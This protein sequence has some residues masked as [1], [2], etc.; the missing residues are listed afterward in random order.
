M[1]VFNVKEFDQIQILLTVIASKYVNLV[2]T[3]AMQGTEESSTT[4]HLRFLIKF[5]VALKMND[6]PIVVFFLVRATHYQSSSRIG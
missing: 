5:L 1:I 3:L 2:S 4:D 6:S